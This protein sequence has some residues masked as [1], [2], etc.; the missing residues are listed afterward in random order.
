MFERSRHGD[1][2]RK[3]GGG[4]LLS[5]PVGHYLARELQP[6]RAALRKNIPHTP[7]FRAHAF[8]FLFNILVAAI[9]VIH[10][11]NDRLAIRHQRGKHQ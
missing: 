1:F 8:Q 11:V 7:D 4:R 3:R 9:D 2:R 5:L 6:L 10:P